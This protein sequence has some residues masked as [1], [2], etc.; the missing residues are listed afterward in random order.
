MDQKKYRHC[1]F[2]QYKSKEATVTD[3]P[4]K[5]LVTGAA[6]FIGFH[7]A[8]ELMRRGHSVRAFDNLNDYYSVALKQDRLK[9]LSL[10]PL[11]SFSKG[12]FSEFDSVSHCWADFQ[13]THVLHLG[14]Q[15]GVRYSLEN[16][17]VYIQSNVVGFQNVIDLVKLHRPRNFVYASSSSVYGKSG[18]I[19][20]SEEQPCNHPASL[21]AATKISN[22]LIARTYADLYS[23]PTI[24]LRFFTVYGAWYRPDMAMFRF[25]D[26]MV[27]GEEIHVYNEGRMT[28]DFTYVDDIVDGVL[29]ALEH[30]SVGEVYNL[31]KGQPDQLIEMIRI[32]EDSLGVKAKL[33]MMPMQAGDVEAT[34]ADLTKSSCELGYIPRTSL[35][36]GIP[37]FAR[38]YREYFRSA[39]RT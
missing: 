34:L 1:D 10:N 6:G 4:M 33:K 9:L 26:R 5:V 14:A 39:S 22:E 25:A 18:R 30:P 27:R 19:P 37:H 24:G 13:P 12:D 3:L 31:G 38:W 8:L 35:E 2:G 17:G 36:K 28:R 32:L 23:I 7:A 29:R 21:Y 15:A 16:P 11:F 20:F